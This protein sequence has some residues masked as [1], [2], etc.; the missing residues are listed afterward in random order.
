MEFGTN[1]VD[2][3]LW[4]SDEREQIAGKTRSEVHDFVRTDVST[5]SAVGW[6]SMIEESAS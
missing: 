5:A 1:L 4:I 2:V 6:V 3:A